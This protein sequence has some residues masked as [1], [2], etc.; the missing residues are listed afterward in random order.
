[1]RFRTRQRAGVDHKVHRQRRFVYA[2]HRQAFGVVFVGDG[3]ADAD[4]FDTG[5]NH[6]VAS[7]GFFK[8]YALQAFKTQK[9]VDA[10]LGDLLLVVHDGN[11]LAGFDA[12]VQDATDAEADSVVVVVELGDLQ[13][14]R[15]VRAAARCGRVF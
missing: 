1:M 4:V 8:R 2:Q 11:G 12:S 13:L 7:F 3:Y 14:Q 10:A 15:L 9:L 6:D 5:N